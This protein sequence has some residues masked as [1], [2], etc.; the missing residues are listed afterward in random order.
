MSD[1]VIT[2]SPTDRTGP[3]GSRG[4]HKAH[5]LVVP[6]KLSLPL[7]SPSGLSPVKMMGDHAKAVKA[8]EPINADSPPTANI[9]WLHELRSSCLPLGI[10]WWYKRC[11]S[12]LRSA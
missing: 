5:S 9:R 8:L 3:D 4:Y 11:H 7:P 10:L 6:N 2:P 12:S 1:L